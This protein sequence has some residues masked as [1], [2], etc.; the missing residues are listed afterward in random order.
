M[1]DVNVKPFLAVGFAA[2]STI[3]YRL[4]MEPP[5][6][7]RPDKDELNVLSKLA[8][9]KTVAMKIYINAYSQFEFSLSR[10]STDR[11]NFSMVIYAELHLCK[12]PIWSSG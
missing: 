12:I 10:F 6:M 7:A 8:T 9:V 1:T 2:A 11:Y 5:N 4:V 3:I